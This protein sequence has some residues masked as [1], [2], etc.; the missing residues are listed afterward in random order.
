M[1]EEFRGQRILPGYSPWGHKE[2]D[3]TE[4]LTLSFSLSETLL[5]V[6]NYFRVSK[7]FPGD[8]V[9]KEAACNAGDPARFNLWVRKIPWRRE[10][11]RKLPTPVFLPGESHGQRNLVGYS[12]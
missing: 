12:P 7:G 2:S 3:I 10:A 6:T 11:V 5:V 4:Q 9:G 8:S 1:P